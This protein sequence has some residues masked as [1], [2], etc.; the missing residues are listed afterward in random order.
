MVKRSWLSDVL[1][2]V[3]SSA[4]HVVF[5]T[6]RDDES[7]TRAMM[8]VIFVLSS[9]LVQELGVSGCCLSRGSLL[10]ER[11]RCDLA[12]LDTRESMEEHL[13]VKV[14]KACIPGTNEE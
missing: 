12:L 8:Y 10:G 13:N 3:K 5:V 4:Q 11:L 1:L 2:G 9:G 7:P 6:T 14:A